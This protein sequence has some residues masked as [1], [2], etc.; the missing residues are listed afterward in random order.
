MQNLQNKKILTNK[1]YCK[2]AKSKHVLQRI[3][4]LR[5]F[6]KQKSVE[7]ELFSNLLM[8]TLLFS[9]RCNIFQPPFTPPANTAVMPTSLP[10]VPYLL[11]FILSVWQVER[12]NRIF[13]LGLILT[14]T[15]N[16]VPGT[17]QILSLTVNSVPGTGQILSLTVNFV[18]GLDRTYL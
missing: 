2:K 7:T 13:R 15:V 12:Q 16:F 18:Q 10:L 4:L 17:G 8:K 5:Q 3:R 11:F 1:K 14:L 9:C 6:L